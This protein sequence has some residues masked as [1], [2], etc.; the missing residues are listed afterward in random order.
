MEKPPTNA[1]NIELIVYK[2]DELKR[3]VQAINT[4]LD[5]DYVTQ[6]QFKPVRENF[7]SK[8]EFAPIQK[9]G[10]GV[11]AIILTAVFGGLVALVVTK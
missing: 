8:S 11:V 1:E 6:D 5:K 7:V 4:K 10:Y 2:I 3:D 9:I